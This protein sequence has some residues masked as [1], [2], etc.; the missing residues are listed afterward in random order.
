MAISQ[1]TLKATMLML[2]DKQNAK[3]RVL[4]RKLQTAVVDPASDWPLF[5]QKSA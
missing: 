1:T 4:G 2:I 3:G 5:A